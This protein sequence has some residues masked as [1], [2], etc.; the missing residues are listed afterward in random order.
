M[1]CTEVC[2]ALMFAFMRFLVALSMRR[3]V[4]RCKKWKDLG[5]GKL[6]VS[7]ILFFQFLEDSLTIR[8]YM[9]TRTIFI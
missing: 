5:K 4:K 2:R 3:K 7:F 1:L 8:R 6:Y 9:E